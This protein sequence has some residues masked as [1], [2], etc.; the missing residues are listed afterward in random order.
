MCAGMCIPQ[1]WGIAHRGECVQRG[2]LSRNS[3]YVFEISVGTELVRG[4]KG[5]RLGIQREALAWQLSDRPG[6]RCMWPI[7]DGPL[8]LPEASSLVWKT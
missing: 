4:G 2:A 1:V 6:L 8:R 3:G 7:W 5:G